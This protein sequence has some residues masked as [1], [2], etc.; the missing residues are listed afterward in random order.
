VAGSRGADDR[1]AGEPL[2]YP[3]WL[4]R[5]P[6]A[7]TIVAFGWLEL[8]YVDRQHPATLA[9]LAC[10]YAS[11]QLVGMAAFGVEVWSERA[12]GF[13]VA[14]N[15]YS[16]LSPLHVADG[17]LRRRRPLSALTSLQPMPG[18]VALVCALIG[19]T[20]FD[21]ATNGSVWKNVAKPLTRGLGHLGVPATPALELS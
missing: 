2:P 11:I 4:G 8:V 7:A 19:T 17:V 9:V 21:G 12:D 6:A 14:F 13:A 20:T 10:A 1:G 16:R 5:W 18:T 3:A 15:L